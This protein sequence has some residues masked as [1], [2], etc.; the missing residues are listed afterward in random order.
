MTDKI[1]CI[2]NPDPKFKGSCNYVEGPMTFPLDRK[3][4]ACMLT[5]DPCR[6]C[7]NLPYNRPSVVP[8]YYSYPKLNCDVYFGC[9]Y[10]YNKYAGNNTTKPPAD[11][12]SQDPKWGIWPVTDNKS[13]VRCLTNLQDT[14]LLN[15]PEN[16]MVSYC[17]K[18]WPR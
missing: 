11:E 4:S 15:C 16:N 1:T 13:C 12:C 10:M 14:K 17:N 7:N 9:D 18:A 5:E 3:Y 8:K 6:L 2:K